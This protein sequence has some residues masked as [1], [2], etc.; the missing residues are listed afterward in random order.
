MRTLVD[1]P[2]GI[3]VI[4]VDEDEKYLFIDH[5]LSTD[6]DTV[7]VAYVGYR[8]NTIDV[9]RYCD[10]GH[11][12]GNVTEISRRDIDEYYGEWLLEARGD[13]AGSGETFEEFEIDTPCGAIVVSPLKYGVSVGLREGESIKELIRAWYDADAD[14][15]RVDAFGK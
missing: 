4:C 7:S 2:L 13:Y 15:I 11:E 6:D 10:I 14:V 12:V 1:T 9:K 8:V 3:L 5:D